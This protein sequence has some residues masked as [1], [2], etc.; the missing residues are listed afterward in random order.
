MSLKHSDDENF[1]DIANLYLGA[2]TA[3]MQNMLI[4]QIRKAFMHIKLI[5]TS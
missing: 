4:S 1:T 3:F 2:I 5:W